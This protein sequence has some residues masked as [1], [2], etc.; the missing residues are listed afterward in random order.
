M[1][2]HREP[3]A[4]PYAESLFEL[5]R[6]DRKLDDVAQELDGVVEVVRTDPEIREF[7]RSA[8]IRPEAKLAFLD[9]LLG[10]K[11]DT[12]FLNFLKVLTKHGRFHALEDVR[13]VFHEMLDV[14]AG[15]VRAKLHTA[16]KASDAEVENVRRFVKTK[17]GKDAI[18]ENIVRPSLIGGFVLV[19][20][21][22]LVDASV[23]TRLSRMRTGLLERGVSEIRNRSAKYSDM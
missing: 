20:G 7:F 5:A 6:D 14:H 3:A 11:V 1:A 4:K 22:S 9:K 12:V 16:A 10:G 23:S 8:R 18:V 17:T 21:D 19:V 13:S 2:S 15:R